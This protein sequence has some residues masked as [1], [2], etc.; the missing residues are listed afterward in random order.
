[1]AGRPL[2]HG[3][4]GFRVGPRACGTWSHSGLLSGVGSERAPAVSSPGWSANQLPPALT[5]EA[6]RQPKPRGPCGLACGVGHPIGLW[7]RRMPRSTGGTGPWRT[8][9]AC[10]GALRG[11]RG[12]RRAARR[13]SVRLTASHGKA[14]A[15]TNDTSCLPEPS[16]TNVRIMLESCDNLARRAQSHGAMFRRHTEW[17]HVADAVLDAALPLRPHRGSRCG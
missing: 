13:T 3:F 5:R 8:P 15:R 4:D 9:L 16:G 7:A 6:R 12:H 14:Y 10:R 2:A 1:M 11:R 17:P